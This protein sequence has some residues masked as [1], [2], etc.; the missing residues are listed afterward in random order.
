[1][2]VL[3]EKLMSKFDAETEVAKLKT[4]LAV[5]RKTRPFK[6]KLDKYRHEL[7]RLHE[8][9]ASL[10]ALQL[11]LKDHKVSAD[12]STISRWLMRHGTQKQP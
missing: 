8:A 11:Y 3:S 1:L 2:F 7:I 4:R 5:R 9:G 10:S 12:R 6:S